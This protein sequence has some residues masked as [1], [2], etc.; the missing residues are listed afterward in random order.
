M[1]LNSFLVSNQ[2]RL[3]TGGDYQLPA[4]PDGTTKLVE[5]IVEIWVDQNWKSVLHKD[6]ITT[7]DCIDN[8]KW[9]DL[10]Y[11]FNYIDDTAKVDWHVNLSVKQ[12]EYV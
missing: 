3:S 2:N 5:D 9:I 7:N 6:G 4:A 8:R 12:S 10:A 1:S 11:A